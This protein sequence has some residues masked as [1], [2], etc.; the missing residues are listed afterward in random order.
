MREK[1]S[2]DIRDSKIRY[3]TNK[4]AIGESRN[5]PKR[6][7]PIALHLSQERKKYQENIGSSITQT[8]SDA[9]V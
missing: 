4:T 3:V 6:T 2:V 9:L 1:L 8:I 5:T 7:V